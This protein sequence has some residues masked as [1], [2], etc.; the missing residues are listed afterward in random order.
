MTDW[1]TVERQNTATTKSSGERGFSAMS[2]A[3]FEEQERKIEEAKAG[4]V[5]VDVDLATRAI[6]FTRA[7][8]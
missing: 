4:M 7:E 3:E 8:S 2:R 1:Q 5:V 6:H